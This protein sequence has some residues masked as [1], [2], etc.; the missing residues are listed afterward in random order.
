MQMLLYPHSDASDDDRLALL[1]DPLLAKK[2]RKA[3]PTFFTR[4]GHSSIA[5]ILAL[6]G[7]VSLVSG[8]FIEPVV[9]APY[10]DR[11][12]MLTTHIRQVPP[13]P[14][15]VTV[16]HHAP[17]AHAASVVTVPQRTTTVVRPE[18]VPQLQPE[19]Q[20]KRRA[21]AVALTQMQPKVQ[22]QNEEQFWLKAQAQAR[23][24]DRARAEDTVAV[25]PAVDR[26]PAE[27]P[28]KVPV[29]TH[30]P[31][32]QIPSPQGPVSGPRIPDPSG[33]QWPTLPGGGPC[34]PGRGP[35]LT[36]GHGLAGALI[37]AV[38]QNAVPVHHTKP[39]G[40]P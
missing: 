34:T 39:F 17:P 5:K 22:G 14:S 16:R 29:D 21:R 25:G 40:R 36:G 3:N 33:G 38:L 9:F 20:V 13:V 2:L 24:R 28:N 7:I 27:A 26:A 35:I 19:K 12:T 15:H 31:T 32:M 18:P 37:N 1:A 10:R 6:A 23:A 30:A 4:A 11:E 8:Y